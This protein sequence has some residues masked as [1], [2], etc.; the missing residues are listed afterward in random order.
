[1]FQ[2]TR[3]P[4][5]GSQ[6]HYLAKNTGLVQRRYRRPTDVVSVMAAQYDLCGVCVVFCVSVYSIRLH[7]AQHTG[8]TGHIMPT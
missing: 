1:M 3:K 8:H 7:S 5:S 4:S 6:N 2:F